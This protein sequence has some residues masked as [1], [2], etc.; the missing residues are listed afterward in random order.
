[1]LNVPIRLC[2]ILLLGSAACLMTS[3]PASAQTDAVAA[4]SATL[5]ETADPQALRGKYCPPS[6]PMAQN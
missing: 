1:M 6:A 4:S 3:V 2:R 5:A